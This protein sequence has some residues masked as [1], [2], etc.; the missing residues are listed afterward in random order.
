MTE[1]E[2]PL[3]SKVEIFDT[4][5]RDGEQS[6]GAA[7]SP[8]EKVRLARQLDR[9]GV[10]VIEAGFPI[11][12]SGEAET[13][14]QIAEVVER[15]Q[16][17]ALCRT[18]AE[19][20]DRAWA[21]IKEAARPRLH[22]F[23][24]TSPLHLEHKLKMS[25][26]E[27]IDAVRE[28]V[29]R[30]A[31]YT[32]NVEFSAEDATRSEL[33][34][35]LEV[36]EAAMESGARVLNIPDTVGYTTP[37]EYFKLISAV[38]AQIG[39]R[40]VTISAHCHDDLGL[41]VA[42]SLAAIRAGARQIEGCI[43]GIGERAGNAALEEVI[44]ALHTRR[45]LFGCETAIDTQLLVST[46]R[47][48]SELTGMGL[49]PNKAIIGQNAFAHESGIH[50]HGVLERRETYEIMSPEDV[51]FS[52]NRIVLGKLSG[53]HALADRLEQLGYHLDRAQL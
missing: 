47:M 19:D 37:D 49:A 8:A 2:S 35:L 12:S 5:L 16:V 45:D 13:V 10:D 9:L 7:L 46:S 23:I 21:S 50:Q 42:N 26:A 41:A 30:C 28:G 20:I 22:I 52:T 39:A 27:V 38:N 4:T 15:A 6:R 1:R 34:F 51:G 24:A 48:V 36:F 17:A 53:R 44:M 14:R 3:G 31:R 33:P 43:N 18:R 25:E 11:A 32:E 40:P 29:S